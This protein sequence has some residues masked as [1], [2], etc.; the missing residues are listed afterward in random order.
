MTKREVI[1][2]IVSITNEFDDLLFDTLLKE[3]EDKI[4]HLLF[5]PSSDRSFLGR[6]VACQTAMK[7]FSEEIEHKKTILK[8][9][10]RNLR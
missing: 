3:N 1:L 7:V 9:Q 10:L 4:A 2:N 5:I 8:E 6:K